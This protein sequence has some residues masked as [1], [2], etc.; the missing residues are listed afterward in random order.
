MQFSCEENGVFMI[1]G[2]LVEVNRKYYAILNLKHPDG[3]RQQ[4]RF[5]LGLPVLNNKRR[6]QEKLNELCVEYTRKQQVEENHPDVILTDFLKTWI[7]S[8]KS[9]LS[10]TTYRNYLHMAEHHM[11]DYFG[12]TPIRDVNFQMIE[13]Y[14]QYLQK[15][16]LSFTMIQ[17]HHMLLQSIFR[18]A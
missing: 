17:H 9:K 14:Y 4:K 3:Q 16:G 8:R 15:R 11:R 5:D 12:D 10:P 6:A 1:T 13:A 18:E 2:R 7:E